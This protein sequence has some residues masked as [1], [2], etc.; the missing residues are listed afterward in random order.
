MSLK[1]F[2][3]IKDIGSGSFGVVLLV[4]RKQDNKIYALKRVKLSNLILNEKQNSLNEINFLS[5]I[6][7]QNIIEYKESFYEEET[8]TLN[9]VLEYANEGDLNTKI[10]IQKSKKIHFKEKTIWSI[11]IQIV[12]GLKVLHDNNLIH[13]DLKSAN[14]LIMKNGI[15]KLGDLNISK[16]YNSNFHNSKMGTP[17]YAA[18]EIWNNKPY[19]FKSDIWSLGII[20]Y[21]LCTFK[22]PFFAVNIKEIYNKIMK[23]KFD[24]IPNFYSFSL[25]YVI[26]ML[27]NLDPKKRPSCKDILNND[28]V[29]KEI[30]N[31]FGFS[32]ANGNSEILSLN[33]S[34]KNIS[35]LNSKE[36]KNSLPHFKNYDKDK[37]EKNK[38]NF[39]TSN[40]D[41]CLNLFK[42]INVNV[43]NKYYRNDNKSYKSYNNSNSNLSNISNINEKLITEINTKNISLDKSQQLMKIF[44]Y[45]DLKNKNS[46]N[47]K[48]NRVLINKDNKEYKENNN[49]SNIQIPPLYSLSTYQNNNYDN[50]D[51][52]SYSNKINNSSN[53]SKLKISIDLNE[54]SEV[55]DFLLFK[56]KVKNKERIQVTRCMFHNNNI[57]LNNDKINHERL[58]TLNQDNKENIKNVINLRKNKNKIY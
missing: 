18:P 19:T 54:T 37:D 55:N 38:K 17:C 22:L 25:N 39:S 29:K 47:L 50:S 27:L 8:G 56:N 9:L 28:I 53:N 31:V 40:Y 13:R 45:C 49:N 30:D 43:N 35:F 11:F 34:N 12:K 36:I 16:I 7:H 41:S 5:S 46:N 20:L 21:E 6:S 15:C 24:P 58:L 3:I 26:K 23:G 42:T 14:I 51:R 33:C 1:D 48:K 4:K 44:S 32:G 10:K 52:Y 57:S 2:K